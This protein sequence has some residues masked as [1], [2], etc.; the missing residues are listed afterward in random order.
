MKTFLIEIFLL[1]LELVVVW[2]YRKYNLD[3]KEVFA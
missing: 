3:I 1:L 2:L